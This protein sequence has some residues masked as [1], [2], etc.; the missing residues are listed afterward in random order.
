MRMARTTR[1]A[2]T[3]RPG[4]AVITVVLAVLFA[5]GL[6][7]SVR[8]IVVDHAWWNLP[9]ATLGLALI[10]WVGIAAWRCIWA[11]DGPATGPR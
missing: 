9:G 10:W 3:P 6:V 8:S 7:G 5:L 1:G 11:P 2:R 4:W